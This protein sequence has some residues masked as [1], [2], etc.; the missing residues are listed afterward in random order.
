MMAWLSASLGRVEFE[1]RPDHEL[2]RLGG[3]TS[4]RGGQQQEVVVTGHQG[5]SITYFQTTIC[6]TEVIRTTQ[7][8]LPITCP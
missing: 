1:L 7:R 4:F 6:Y 8:C 3:S 2:D 5:G